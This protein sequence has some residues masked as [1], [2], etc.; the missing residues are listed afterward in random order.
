MSLTSDDELRSRE[1]L[2]A[3]VRKLHQDFLQHGDAWD[4]NTLATFLEAL[5]AWVH[6]SPGFYQNSG[7]ELP[8]GGDWTFIAR[9]LQAAKVYE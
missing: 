8:A 3:F 9:A 2:A 1:E 4:N 6:D 5:A 7:K